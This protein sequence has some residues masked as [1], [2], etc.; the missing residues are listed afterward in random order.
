M[1]YNQLGDN[2]SPFSGVVNISPPGSSG[3]TGGRFCNLVR[4]PMEIHISGSANVT[5][6]GTW[7]NV[8][9]F[10]RQQ[11]QSH[12]RTSATLALENLTSTPRP[13]PPSMG[14]YICG[15]MV[16]RTGA[17]GG[18]NMKLQVR[19]PRTS[20]TLVEKNAAAGP[21]ILVRGLIDDRRK[22]VSWARPGSAALHRRRNRL[23]S[24][25]HILGLTST[26]SSNEPACDPSAR[27]SAKE[28][29]L[30]TGH[31]KR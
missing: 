22:P 12:E 5:M 13:V 17:N 19:Q 23:L 28:R 9:R 10:H 24:S 11:L 27:T 14:S 3:P 1:F 21:A 18:T 30:L 16:P 7:Y 4:D 8:E 20:P 29:S 15:G 26:S 31:R 25:V 6:P 2:I